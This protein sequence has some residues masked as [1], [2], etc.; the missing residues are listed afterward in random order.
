MDD[1]ALLLALADAVEGVVRAGKRAEYGRHLRMGADGTPTT[2]VDDLA[3]VEILRVLEEHGN[4]WNVLSEEAGRIDHGRARTLVMDPI[5]G[6]RN[7]ARGL[8][9]FCVSLALCERTM[10]DASLGVVRNLCTG[11]TFVARRGR[12]AFLNGERLPLVT[13]DSEEIVV[14]VEMGSVA[15]LALRKPVPSDLLRKPFYVRVLGSA[16]LEMALVAQGAMDAYVHAPPKVRVIDVA[17]SSLILREAGGEAF[18]VTGGERRR[19]DMPLDLG[20]R[21]GIAAVRDKS[22]LGFL[23]Y[24]QEATA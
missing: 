18:D 15:T 5:D 20:Q 24:W 7:A 13:G 10:E 11:D 23:D 3:E 6:T 1:E 19:L 4:P 17:A 16:A 12:G 22:A 14:S 21:V 2:F 9:A 8:P